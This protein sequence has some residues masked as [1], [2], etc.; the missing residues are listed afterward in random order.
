MNGTRGGMGWA[1]RLLIGLI[2]IILGAAAAVWALARYEKAAEFLGVSPVETPVRSALPA[3]PVPA[4]NNLA[5][6]AAQPAAADDRTRVAEIEARLAHVERTSQLAAGSAGRADALVVAFAARRAIDRGAP[7]GFLENLLVDR[8]GAQ[9]ARAVATI[10]SASRAPVRLDQL[11]EEFTQL[12][13]DLRGGGSG[14]SWWAGFRREIGSLV[15][16]RHSKTPST[17]PETRYRRASSRLSA[18]DVEGALAEAMRLPGAEAASSW[19]AKA[20]R[21]IAAHQALDELESAALMSGAAG[22]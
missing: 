6:P 18:G 13:P 17:K 9:H 15:E 16:I 19:V 7:L 2:L 14:E 4:L 5:P 22:R 21:Y 3:P 1:G 20:R 10:I 8:F 12:E 11:N